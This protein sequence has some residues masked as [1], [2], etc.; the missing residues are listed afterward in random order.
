MPG[1]FGLSNLYVPYYSLVCMQTG[2]FSWTCYFLRH[3]GV[4][5]LGQG[6]HFAGSFLYYIDSLSILSYIKYSL[7]GQSDARGL[8]AVV[9]TGFRLFRYNLIALTKDR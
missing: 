8:Y 1:A 5:F 9:R 3:L 4:S 6:V 2:L 7:R